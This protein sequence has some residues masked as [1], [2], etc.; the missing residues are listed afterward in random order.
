M[1]WAD[2]NYAHRFSALVD[3]SSWTSGAVEFSI[4][5]PADLEPFWS[6][7][8]NDGDDIRVYG[9]DG[10]TAIV[11]DLSGFN[12]STKTV[13]IRC[14]GYTPS[15]AGYFQVHVYFG[16]ASATSGAGSP[17]TASPLTS[18]VHQGCESTPLIRVSRER[19][20]DSKPR[21]RVSKAPNEQLFVWWDLYDALERRCENYNGSDLY[22]EIESINFA[23]HSS[24]SPQASM[25]DATKTRLVAGRYIRTLVKA[26]TSGTTYTMVLTVLYSTGQKREHRALL[27]VQTPK[28]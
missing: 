1:S 21:H 13:T 24:D 26:G 20:G 7:I 4:V 8:Q 14:S 19:P 5:V 11:Y 16:Y 18:Y 6:T 23:V 17:T 22:E 27:V 3:A 2:S 15:Q 28:E 12:Y 25:I 9:P 10:R